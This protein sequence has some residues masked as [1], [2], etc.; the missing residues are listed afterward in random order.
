MSRV[1]K[2]K[3]AKAG[4]LD[5]GDL[6]KTYMAV[7]TGLIGHQS[8]IVEL[9]KSNP[10]K[11]VSNPEL[12]EGMVQTVSLFKEFN[13]D[14]SDIGKLHTFTGEDGKEVAMGV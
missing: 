5:Y 12:R 13:K 6:A 14:L 2:N 7:A 4:K 8:G 1:K 11:V 3:P 9:A 10:E